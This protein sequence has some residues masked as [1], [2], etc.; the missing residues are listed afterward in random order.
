MDD[1]L[2][3]TREKITRLVKEK[4][5]WLVYIILAAIVWFGAKI[6]VSNMHLLKDAT[7]G[8][9]IPLALDPHIFLRYAQYI[10]DYGKLIVHD[11]MRYVPLGLA[12]ER[13]NPILPY[14]IAYFYKIIKIFVPSITLAQI[15]IIYPV[16]FF[17][18]ILIFFFLLVRR[19]FDNKVALLST[20]FLAVIPTF[21]Y[22]TMAGFSDKEAFGLFFMFLALY[23]YV[24]AGQSKKLKIAVLFGILSGISTGLMNL[25]WAG[26]QFLF[27]I[28][29]LFS[30]IE[31]FLDKFT[32]KDFYVFTSWL[33]FTTI[34]LFKFKADF[35]LHNLLT[36]TTTSISFLVLLTGAIL[37][38]LIK[39][40]KVLKE[41]I[42]NKIPL[43]IA[44]LCI[45]LLIIIIVSLFISPSFLPNEL[46]NIKERL[47]HPF[48]LGRLT[49]TVA[50]SHQPYFT[51]WKQSFGWFFYLFFIGSIALFYQLVKPLKKFKWYLLIIY[52]A[53]LSAFIF[54]R[55]SVQSKIFNGTTPIA[56][57]FYLGSLIIFLGIIG[58]LYLYSFYKNKEIFGEIKTFDKKY[59]FVFVWF[60]LMIIAARGAMRLFIVLTPIAAIL[61]SYL[62]I[63]AVDF[64]LKLKNK[65]YK[66]ISLTI[67]LLLVFCPI[68]SFSGILVKFARE[69]SN[70]ARY[71]G[72]SYNQQ[73]QQAMK[74][75]RENTA[76]D[77][78]FAHWWDYGYW[79]QT[80]GK[81]ATV[82]DG[83]NFIDHWNYLMGR[84][85][86]TAQNETEAL[87]FLKVHNATHLL[88]ISDEI[89]KYGAYSS[90]GSDED[91]DRYSWIN[92]F[93]LDSARVQETR[94]GTMYL[95]RGGYALDEDFV[96]GNKLFPRMSAGIVA[97]FVPIQEIENNMIIK[98]PIAILSYQGQQTEVPLEC[99]YLDREYNFEK[100]GLKGCL[101]LIPTID[102][103]NR[104]NKGVNFL[105]GALYISERAKRTLWVQLFLLDKKFEYFKEVYNDES[106]IPLAIYQGRLIGPLKI[107]EVSY[108]KNIALRPEYLRKS[109]QKK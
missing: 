25:A 93:T 86:L 74:W 62:L 56:N 90:I 30:L 46:I 1:N 9:Y 44:S 6:R 59:I 8:E 48:G 22:R 87:E 64:S 51:N 83:G 32:K 84:H 57:F 79:V 2:E 69:S 20:A 11:A 108:P 29:A 28:I 55:Y 75:T 41:K 99:V 58:L 98:Q 82:L 38:L 89:G 24:V 31:I 100:P 73:W 97:F 4:K 47:I 53:F 70:S 80:G 85:V 14:T 52:T 50:E 61:A 95:Y 3:K 5:N 68:A 63:S 12:T 16:I 34:I 23:L 7:T 17:I 104:F 60:L 91:F 92:T 33:F 103:D 15:D 94:N 65:I 37:I 27:L 107:W 109:P 26:G 77:A 39:N 66:I 10:I 42:Q 18:P 81:R 96:Y 101:K 78:V 88:I 76:E 54:S 106:S 49:L 35:N 45:S 102:Q 13:A 19:L 105:A 71:S 40:I 72:P 67:I 43:G 36:S 21:L